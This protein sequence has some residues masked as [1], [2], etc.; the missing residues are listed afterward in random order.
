MTNRSRPELVSNKS[1]HKKNADTSLG[2][3]DIYVERTYVFYAHL[4]T[5][6]VLGMT[7]MASE[8]TRRHPVDSSNTHPPEHSVATFSYKRSDSHGWNDLLLQIK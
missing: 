2:E 7:T 5:C 4:H 6:N 1:S 8:N 3:K